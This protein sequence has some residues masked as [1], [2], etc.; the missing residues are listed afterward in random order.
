MPVFSERKCPRCGKN[1]IILDEELDELFC[2]DCGY[3]I[4]EKYQKSGLAITSDKSS[5]KNKETSLSQNALNIGSQTMIN[6]RNKD[7]SGKPISTNLYFTRLR[8]LENRNKTYSS[9]EKNLQKA[10]EEMSK[11]KDEL[12]LSDTIIDEAV[13]LYQKIIDR[14]LTRG[15]SINAHVGACIYASCKITETPRT[16]ES[17]ANNLG[18]KKIEIRRSY[19]MMLKELELK[20]PLSDPVRFVA[21][22]ASIAGFGEKTKREA[23]K[24]IEQAKKTGI[25]IG[26]EPRGIAAGALHVAGFKTEEPI[27][28]KTIADA[29]GITVGT[30]IERSKDFEKISEW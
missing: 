28:E 30:L 9:A 8:K 20:M 16:M 27:S 2:S 1:S 3:V 19:K 18:M 17:I 14:K 11:L 24:M 12:V 22:I 29:S 13:R 25:I 4:T 10:I 5:N 7:S 21:R 23:I 15:Y 26:K 6:P